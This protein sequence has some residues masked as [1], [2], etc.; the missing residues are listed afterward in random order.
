[1]FIGYPQ[2]VSI[3]LLLVPIQL[4]EHPGATLV[5]ANHFP[6]QPGVRRVTEQL[7]KRLGVD[8]ERRVPRR[9]AV[10]R[11]EERLG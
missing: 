6:F 7:V 9:R 3:A 11:C 4:R 8:L 1:M 10:R 2:G 5:R